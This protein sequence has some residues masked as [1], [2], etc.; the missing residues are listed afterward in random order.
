MSYI[1][2][3]TPTYPTNTYTDN[4]YHAW[5][6]FEQ[7][8]N[9]Y[10]SWQ[11]NYGMPNCTAYAWARFWTLANPVSAT[12]NRPTL[13]LGNAWR[14]WG[15]TEDGYS[16]GQV[17]KLGA[18]ICFRDPPDTPPELETGGHVAIVEE[19]FPDGSIRVSNSGYTDVQTDKDRWWFWTTTLPNDYSYP[20]TNWVFQGFIY[21]PFVDDDKKLPI[22]L[23]RRK[24]NVKGK[25]I[26][27]ATKNIR[28]R[29]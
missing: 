29:K 15:Y 22:W 23:M 13:S 6:P 24:K 4:E 14:W 26:F 25:T 3:L 12:D 10:R 11:Q 28:T 2:Q 20:N 19:I 9:P 17:A 1:P 7:M 8:Y 5:D 18:I 16:R 27:G 21:N